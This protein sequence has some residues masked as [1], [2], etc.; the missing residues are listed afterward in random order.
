MIILPEGSVKHGIEF[1]MCFHHPQGGLGVEGE[2]FS[3]K[4]IIDGT[5]QRAHLFF[6]SEQALPKKLETL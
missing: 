4:S 1:D 5:A 3:T 2:F 6:L